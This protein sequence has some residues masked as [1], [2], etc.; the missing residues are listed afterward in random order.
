VILRDIT[1]SIKFSVA[2]AGICLKDSY[3]ERDHCRSWCLVWSQ[4]LQHTLSHSKHKGSHGQDT[5]GKRND[6]HEGLY[7][8]IMSQDALLYIVIPDHL[9][10]ILLLSNGDLD[11]PTVISSYHTHPSQHTTHRVSHSLTH[12]HSHTMTHT[13]ILSHANTHSRS[14][15]RS[16]ALTHLSSLTL[17]LS[18]SQALTHSCSNSLTLSQSHSKA[19]TF[20]YSHK[21][22]RGVCCSHWKLVM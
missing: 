6:F 16:Q 9:P 8:P 7:Q 10:N 4:L 15:L 21:H 11:I 22:T 3:V 13:H 5:N 18:Y 20:S 14:V 1:T 19:L 17:T 2:I 12:S